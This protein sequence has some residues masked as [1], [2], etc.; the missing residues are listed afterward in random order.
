MAFY[1]IDV[2]PGDGSTKTF[3][4]TFDFIN[5]ASVYVFSVDD[6]SN[7]QTLL[8]AVTSGE[9]GSGQYKWDSD[10]QITLGDALPEGTSVKIQR[11]T[12]QDLQ[13]VQWKDGSY[14]IAEELN[15]SDKQWLF[16]TQELQ[17]AILNIDG[18]LGPAKAVITTQQATA[19]P[20]NPAWDSDVYLASAGAIDRV[21]SQEVG[22]GSAYPGD[23]NKGKTGRLRID[24]TGALPK[25]FYWNGDAATPAWVE[26][27][28]EGTAGPTGPQGPPGPPPGL[29]NPAATA[30]NVPNKG[31]GALGTATASVYQISNG[32]LQFN[33]GIPV[34][35]KGAD[36][37][38]GSDGNAA[39][40]DVGTTS[41]L[42]PG[43]N[44]TVV[45]TGDTNAAVLSFGIPR[46][47]TGL[48]GPEGTAATVN[49]G[50]TTTSAPGGDATVVN[51]GNANAAVL[52]FTIPRGE[53]GPPGDGVTYRGPIDPVTTQAPA[54]VGGDFYVSTADGTPAPGWTGVESVQDGTRLIYNANSFQW[55]AYHPV[56]TNIPNDGQINISGGAGITATGSNA[57]AN[58]S[59]NTTRTLAVDTTW[60]G[61]WIGN[62][63]NYLSAGDN[64][65]ELTNDAGYITAAEVPTPDASNWN[66]DDGSGTLTPKV[67]TDT[68][69]VN[70][71]DADVGQIE[72]LDAG[73]ILLS[74]LDPLP[75]PPA[76][77]P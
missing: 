24:N 47:E 32:D 65:S 42:S 60:L 66:R 26:I 58:Q 4:L 46:G 37:S 27:Q 1:S 67:A 54:A 25:L 52:N 49:V 8:T 41:T 22:D 35:Q 74:R 33:F 48:T 56:A 72:T 11:D 36:G 40:V 71:L 55:D 2:Y 10:K 44:A 16:L 28:V 18:V 7:E 13:I 19:D 15:T 62:N 59:A 30:S 3:A 57:T 64:V 20:T 70:Q 73:T 61:T 38:D 14:I 12:P 75:E 43:S 31:N 53:Q 17:D 76:T 45:N 29:Q 50:S 77:N 51:A 68:V 34:G 21:Y 23:G 5:R 63:T 6:T 69:S 9:P 39:T